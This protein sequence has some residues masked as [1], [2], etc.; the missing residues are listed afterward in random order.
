M[1]AFLLIIVNVGCDIV[2]PLF[3]SYLTDYLSKGVFNE[4]VSI[5]VWC[6]VGSFAIAI[7]NQMFLYIESVLLTHIG[8]E[9]IYNIRMEVFKHI[10]NMSQNQFTEMPVGSLVTRVANYTSSMADFYTST[11]VNII[12]YI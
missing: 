4:G 12:R 2:T 11:V 10:E 3:T 9:I 6:A 8:Q 1:I 5:I 7:F